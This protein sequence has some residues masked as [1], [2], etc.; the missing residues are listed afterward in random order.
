MLQQKDGKFLPVQVHTACNTNKYKE[1]VLNYCLIGFAHVSI[2][3][4]C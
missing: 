3:K 4:E 2:T 1:T